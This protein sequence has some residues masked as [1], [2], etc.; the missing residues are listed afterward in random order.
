MRENFLRPEYTQSIAR[1]LAK[2]RSINLV[3]E[4]GTGKSRFLEDIKGDRK[5]A[6]IHIFNMKHY[7]KDYF[8]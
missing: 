2:G 6:D 7:R 8:K 4:S 1:E 3:S 5:G